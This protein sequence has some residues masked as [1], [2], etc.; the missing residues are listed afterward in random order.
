[1]SHIPNEPSL[2]TRGGNYYLVFYDPEKRPKQKWVP[3]KTKQKRTAT[4]RA[5]P[6]EQQYMA[7]VYDP[8]TEDPHADIPTVDE[9]VETFL[10]ARKAD[11]TERTWRTY[12]YDLEPLA[13]RFRDLRLDHLDPAEVD[14]FC[15]RGDVSNRTI[16][17]RLT[18]V[19]TL[20][21]W[22]VQRD[23]LEENP[24]KNL[25]P[26]RPDTQPPRY[27]T[28]REVE[29]LLR[30]IEGYVDAYDAGND[31]AADG[32]QQQASRRWLLHAV[33]L[34]LSTGMRRGS[35]VRL[36]VS[37]VGPDHI[38]VPAASA[39]RDGYTIPLFKDTKDVLKD[40]GRTEGLLLQRQNGKPVPGPMLSKQFSRFRE[41][42]G[43]SDDVT[44][45]TLRHTFASW[46]VQAGVPLFKV[47]SWLGHSSIQVT[48]RYAHLAPNQSDERAEDVFS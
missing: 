7:G 42:A 33:R 46:L 5:A 24:V 27:L 22:F 29:V 39:K 32:G 18:E 28:R 1:M 19:K 11:L 14:A 9:A 34:A 43:L 26:P 23:K 30:E 20:F 31:D 45:H 35:L 21:N 47:S 3:L 25:E 12:K 10:E 16:E 40:I 48:E 41:R 38:H 13:E 15:R 17:K 37:D 2:Y 4:K 8:W 6:L 36:T 44:F